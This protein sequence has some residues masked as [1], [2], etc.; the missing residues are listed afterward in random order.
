VRSSALICVLCLSSLLSCSSSSPPP[1]APP[2][3]IRSIPPPKPEKTPP[4][5]AA[6]PARLAADTLLRT[7]SGGQLTAAKGWF[8]TRRAGLVL[9]EDPSR[10]LAIAIVERKDVEATKAVAGAWKIYQPGFARPVHLTVTPP[11]RDGWEA[12]TQ[13]SYDVPEKEQR[14]AVALAR[15]KSGVWYVALIDGRKAALERR[16]GEMQT[17]LGSLKAPGI[18]EESFRGKKAHLLD[19]TRLRELEVFA[20]AARRQMGLPGVAIAL[21]QGG[22]IIYEKGLGVR[23]LGKAKTVTAR[24]LFLIG[25]ITKS[26]TSLMMA[27]LVDRKKLRWESPVVELMPSFALGDPEATRKLT[28][29]HTVCACTGLPRQDMEMLFEYRGVTPERRLAEMRSMK[30]T[31]GF[32]EA[33]Q[34]SNPM[35]SAGGFIAAHVLH[36][37]KPLGAAYDAAMD[38]LVF[39]PAGMTSTTFDFKRALRADHATPHGMTYQL[40]WKTIAIGDEGWLPAIRPAGGAWSS[41]HDMARYVLLHLRRGLTPEGKRVVSEESLAARYDPQARMSKDQSYGLG[42]VVERSHGLQTIWHTGGTAGFTTEI[43][44]LPEH[45]FGAVLL[46]N[47]SGNFFTGVVHRK[48]LELLFDARDEA[49]ANL[50]H[51]WRRLKDAMAKELAKTTLSPSREWLAKVSGEY[52][53]ASLGKVSVRLQGEK[54]IFDAG[55]WRSSVGRKQERDG[56]QKLVLV[57]PPFNDLELLVGE[58]EGKRTLLLETNQQRYLFVESAGK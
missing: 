8:V 55:E 4:A 53:N 23:E 22:K 9:L 3:A 44:F 2:R 54:G 27:A 18:E 31:T 26:M 32:G 42:L 1:A 29:R 46:T 34:Y 7:P 13:I 30:P 20:E 51:R 45:D 35:V 58:K 5:K 6:P 36:P 28:L 41:A 11:A 25:S 38:A 17:A 12:V 49:K 24:S 21:V 16:G 37:K 43:F 56:T 47:G 10:E 50:E 14:V 33:F 48:L 57:E 19:A 15:R 52:H 39:K 40:T